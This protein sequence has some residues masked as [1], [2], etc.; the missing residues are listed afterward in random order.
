MLLMLIFAVLWGGAW[1]NGQRSQHWG[2]DPNY[3]LEVQE[4]VTVPE[5]L[6]VLVPCSF[7]HPLDVRENQAPAHGYWFTEGTE[8]LNGPPVATNNLSRAVEP[9]AK[10]RF[11]LVGNPQE[12]SCTLMIKDPRREDSK[13]YHFRVERGKA[14]RY[15][16][17][18][19]K[20]YL[21]VTGKDLAEVA[22]GP[23]YLCQ[24]LSLMLG[25]AVGSGPWVTP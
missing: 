1:V 8:T 4:V 21:N 5:G 23:P 3:K 24:P 6:C 22:G 19:K 17:V 18:D 15:N 25:R 20:F 11:Y 16:F 13:W 10:S 14:V 2:L 7:S 12:Y 9:R